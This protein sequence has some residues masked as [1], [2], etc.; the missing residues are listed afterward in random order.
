MLTAVAGAQPIGGETSS[1]ADRSVSSAI[2][3]TAPE[4]CPTAEVFYRDI[5]RR[6]SKLRLVDGSV[7]DMRFDVLVRDEGAKFVGALTV[8]SD[9]S[10]SEERELTAKSCEEV[11]DMF[12]LVVAVAIDPNA[13]LSPRAL[14]T[15]TL[16]PAPPSVPPPVAPSAPP[17]TTPANPRVAAPQ[18]SWETMVGAQVEARGAFA[19]DAALAGALSV[20]VERVHPGWAWALRLSALRSLSSEVKDPAGRAA[21]FRWT[22]ARFDAFVGLRDQRAKVTVGPVIGFDAGVVEASAAL[23]R[24]RPWASLLVAARGRWRPL[25]RLEVEANVGAFTP[26]VRDEFTLFAPNFTIYRER[27]VAGF[28]GCGLGVPLD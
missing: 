23:S 26:I 5:R 12:A 24:A 8:H 4:T 13:S 3:F 7:W 16:A 22:S 25:P 19:T 21:T 6:T 15:T 10:S 20:Q 11:L 27:A 14:P 9:A 18:G 28:L 2:N 17:A 1:A